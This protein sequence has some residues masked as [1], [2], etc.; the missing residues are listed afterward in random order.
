M[1]WFGLLRD[2]VVD[3]HIRWSSRSN[4]GAVEDSIFYVDLRVFVLGWGRVYKVAGIE[5]LCQIN[6]RSDDN[7][8]RWWGR[9][10]LHIYDWFDS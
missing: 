6:A 9:R 10:G 1:R 7:I 4:I 2:I 5:G 3:G 8:R